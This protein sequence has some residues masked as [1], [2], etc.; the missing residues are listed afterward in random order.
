MY[1]LEDQNFYVRLTPS[2][3]IQYMTLFSTQ[4]SDNATNLVLDEGLAKKVWEAS[5]SL[6]GLQPEEQHY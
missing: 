4:V 5:E 1:S 6:V 2:Q 3:Y